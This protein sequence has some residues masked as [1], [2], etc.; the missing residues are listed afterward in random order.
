MP[1]PVM[2]LPHPRCN[3]HVASSVITCVKVF[4]VVLWKA[5]QSSDD[6]GHLRGSEVK[7]KRNCQLSLPSLPYSTYQHIH[8]LP[9]A[10]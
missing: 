1:L 5:L 2:K 10:S 9:T 3:S 6:G 8:L 4:F 7:L